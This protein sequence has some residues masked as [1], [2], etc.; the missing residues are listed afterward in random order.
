MSHKSGEGMPTTEKQKNVKRNESPWT[1]VILLRRIRAESA[2]KKKP[3]EEET[4]QNLNMRENFPNLNN[5]RQREDTEL[6]CRV[7][8]ALTPVRTNTS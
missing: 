2:H 3:R 5:I 6:D 1:N 4:W 7:V 8:I